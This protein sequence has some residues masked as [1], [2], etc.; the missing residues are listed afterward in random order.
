[1]LTT[2]SPTGNETSGS[3]GESQSETE[4]GSGSESNSDSESSTAGPTTDDPS[5]SETTDDP[6]DA[7]TDATTDA[8]TTSD[9]DTTTE[10]PTDATDS[11]SSTTGCMGTGT[12]GDDIDFSYLWIANTSQGSISKINTVTMLEE[13]RYYSDANPG[14]ASPSRTSVSLDGRFTVVANRGSY[15]VSNYASTEEDCI[16]RNN[17]GVI[18]TS[19]NKD[20]L[21]A[22]ADEECRIWTTP[23]SPAP[24]A[25][26]GGPRGITWDPGV[27]NEGTCEYD[28]PKV[29]V[30]WHTSNG[31]AYMA[32]ID[33]KSGVQEA[34]VQIDN[35]PASHAPY[36]A[37]L[38]PDGDV[39]FTGVFQ[40][41]LWKIDTETL[42]LSHWESGTGHRAYGMTVDFN[43][44]PWF[45][46]HCGAVSYFDPINETFHAIPGTNSCH[47]GIVVDRNYQVWVASN[48]GDAGCGLVQIDG[49]TK[50]LVKNHTF[51]QCGTPVGVSIDLEGK[52]WM[53]D[54]NGWAWRMDTETEVKEQLLVAGV[55]YTYS[56]MTGGALK[57][58]FVPE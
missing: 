40:D 19:Q 57:N 15:T 28:A 29:W 47:R 41:D 23:V 21:V 36:G 46:E 22:F 34:T 16:D 42:E 8:P 2:T 18:T 39:W 7:T 50:T 20:D 37:A 17:D 30:G 24:A 4:D 58:V 11:D 38:D 10:D 32:R 54:Y 52:L 53:V 31:I 26:Q 12:G 5:D 27:F 43:G 56:D 51:D 3:M 33:G 44:V 55:H 13:A 9:S 35:W 6:T 25:Y 48:S 49:N 45:G 14:G 1:M